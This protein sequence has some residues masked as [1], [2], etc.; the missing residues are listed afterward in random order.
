MALKYKVVRFFAYWLEIFIFSIIIQSP[1]LIPTFYGMKPDILIPI[2]FS[3]ALIEGERVGFIHGLL[4][5]FLMDISLFG[6]LGFYT[7]SVA[8]FCYLVGKISRN[9]IN[10]NIASSLV[11]CF[12]SVILFIFTEFLFLYLFKGYKNLNYALLYRYL[13]KLGYTSIFVPVMYFF[14]RA[15]GANIREKNK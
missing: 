5:G 12:V 7:I 10:N 14:N 8:I 15:I 9:I 2:A 13:P 3:I 11:V 1:N 4:I 6:H